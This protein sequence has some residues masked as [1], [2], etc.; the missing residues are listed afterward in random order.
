MEIIIGLVGLIIGGG[1]TFFLL[2]VKKK[3]KA[4]LII[5]EANKE[6]EQ[7]KKEKLLQAKEKFIELK[8]EHEKEIAKKNKDINNATQRIS[9]KEN[10]L[11]Q[12]LAVDGD[13]L[14]N[15]K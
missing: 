15:G 5:Q 4:D 11:N 13:S 10:T 6:A 3:G 8:A 9:Q 1:L 12:K 14:I 2:D 7:I